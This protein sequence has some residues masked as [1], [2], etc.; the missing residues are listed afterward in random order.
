MEK[1][2]EWLEFKENMGK[3]DWKGDVWKHVS[4]SPMLED[5]SE[6]LENLY[7][8]EDPNDLLKTTNC[9]SNINIPTSTPLIN[10]QHQHPSSTSNINIPILDDVISKPDIDEAIKNMKKLV[11]IIRYQY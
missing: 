8:T 7:K 6:Y 3:I 10:I 2:V 4:E 11:M 9:K 1:T 5:L